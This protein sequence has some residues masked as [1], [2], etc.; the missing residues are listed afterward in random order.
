VYHYL[1]CGLP[2]VWL[3]N[4]YKLVE[5]EYGSGVS[6][7]KL[8]ELHD[9]IAQAIVSSSQPLTHEEFR[10]IRKELELSQ[11]G[12]AGVLGCDKQSVARWEKAHSKRINP[13]AERFLRLLYQETKMGKQA[14]KPL[15][16][17]LQ[18]IECVEPSE[19]KIEV[20]VRNDSWRGKVAIAA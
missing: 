13:T 5:T 12:L 10:F 4:G 1:G 6:I 19:K 2:N 17:R 11:E 14:L 7:Q 20:R 18:A 15:L 16:E 9:A 3:A 8:H